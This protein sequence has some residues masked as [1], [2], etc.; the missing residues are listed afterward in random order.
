M[1]DVEEWETYFDL[2][3]IVEKMEM[4][5]HNDVVEYGCG[6]GTFTLQLARNT[7]N[8]VYALEIDPEK[9]TFA[10]RRLEK[11]G[12]SNAAFIEQDFM[13]SGADMPENSADYAVMFNLLHC[14]NPQF[15]LQDAFKTLKPGSKLAVI[16]WSCD[17]ETP[18]G[19]D[20]SI[21]PRP[22]QIVAWMQSVGFEAEESAVIDLP[23]WHYG[24]LGTKPADPDFKLPAWI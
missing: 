5:S 1:P 15:L 22:E 16:H 8:W 6:Y 19:P 21:R 9:M 4:T 23:P 7:K 24:V 3:L 10:R 2:P 18:R 20:M 11:A 14:E 13:E 12:I 17:K